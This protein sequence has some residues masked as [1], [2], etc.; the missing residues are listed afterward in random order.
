MVYGKTSG[1]EY[2]GDLPLYVQCAAGVAAAG[3]FGVAIGVVGGEVRSSAGWS[4]AAVGRLGRLGLL[5]LKEA[6]PVVCSTLAELL[7]S[8]DKVASRCRV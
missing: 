4:R 3:V 2:A 8:F 5:V 7:E 1:V 6:S